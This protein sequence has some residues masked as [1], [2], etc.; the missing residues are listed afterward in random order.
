MFTIR[1]ATNI[2]LRGK[3]SVAE[4]HINMKNFATTRFLF[5]DFLAIFQ[6]YR[7]SGNFIRH[8][9]LLSIYQE[10]EYIVHSL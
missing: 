8:N 4:N 3:N 5:P 2:Q 9:L 10:L 1:V 6:V 7:K